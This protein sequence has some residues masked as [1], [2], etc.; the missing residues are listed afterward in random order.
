MKRF[1]CGK[2][3]IKGKVEVFR[4][5]GHRRRFAGLIFGL[6]DTEEVELMVTGITFLGYPCP[7]Q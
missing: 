2:Y 7:F 6:Y 1:Q 5:A 3:L 4:D